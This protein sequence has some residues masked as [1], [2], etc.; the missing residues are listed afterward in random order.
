MAKN[1]SKLSRKTKERV[2]TGLCLQCDAQ[3][4]RRGLCVKHYFRYRT[5]Y[6]LRGQGSRSLVYER[7]EIKAGRILPQLYSVKLRP[8]NSKEAS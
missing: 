2:K 3:A 8:I 4:K 5:Q 7:Q 6:L 1:A